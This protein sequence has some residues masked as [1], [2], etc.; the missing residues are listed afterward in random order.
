MGK[1]RFAFIFII[2][3][4]VF[5]SLS[6]ICGKFAT[7]KTMRDLHLDSKPDRHRSMTMPCSS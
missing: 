4:L 3:S 2:L 5:Q 1:K 7:L 6:I